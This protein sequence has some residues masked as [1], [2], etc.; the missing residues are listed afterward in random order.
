M[1]QKRINWTLIIVLLLGVAVLSISAYS[2]RKW[3]RSRRAESGLS[4]G[5]QAFDNQQWEAAARYLGRYLVVAPTDIPTL[6]KYAEAQLNIRPLKRNNIEQA[7]GAYRTILRVDETHAEAA[8]TLVGIYLQ[9]GLPGEAELI[10]GRAITKNP[11][12]NLQKMLAMAMIEQRKFD[13]GSKLLTSLIQNHPDYIPAYEEIARLAEKR[14]ERISRTSQEWYDQAVGSNPTH[15]A[16]YLLRGSW[17]LR[18]NDKPRAMADFTEAGKLDLSDTAIRL[19]LAELLIEAEDI[20]SAR[21]HLDAIEKSDP[22]NQMLW[23]V[24]AR[25]ALKSNQ[26]QAMKDAADR[27][28]ESLSAQPW[29]FLPVAA[30]LYIRSGHIK[31]AQDCVDRLSKKEISPAATEYLEGIIADKEGRYHDAAKYLYRAIQ[32]DSR[33]PAV[34]L[35]LAD[36]LSRLGDKQSA[37]QQLRMLVSEHP[38]FIGAK[39]SLARLLSESGNWDEASEL[40]RSVA[41]VQPKDTNAAMVYIQSEIQILAQNRTDKDSPL[42]QE[43]E[44]KLAQIEA[45]AENKFPIHLLQFQV[46]VLRSRFDVAGKLLESLGEKYPSRPELVMAQIELLTAQNQIDQAMAKLSGAVREFPES[47]S[48]TAYFATLL[49]EKDQRQ[50]SEQVLRDAL[51]RFKDPAARRQTGLL[52]A[53]FYDRWDQQDKRYETLDSLIRENPEDIILYSQI[54]KC[55]KTIDTPDLAQKMID[56]IKSL[57]GESGYRWRYEQAK[58]WFMD[59]DNGRFN[60]RYPQCVSMLKANLL[61]NPEDQSSR[62]LLAATYERAGELQLAIST[63]LEALDRAPRNMQIIVSTVAA[64]Y[65]ANEYDRVDKILR[66]ATR[67][68]LFHPELERLQLQSYLRRGQLSSAGAIL[69]NLLRNDPNNE[70]ICLSL[71]LLKI[72]QNEFDDAWVLLNKLKA[73]KPDSIPITA[74]EIECSVRQNK[75]QEALQICDNLIGRINT[76]SAYVLR[77]RTFSVLGQVDKA[78]ADLDYA[79]SKNPDDVEALV[80]RSDIYGAMGQS[81]KAIADIQKAMT[82]SDENLQIQM[83]AISLFLNSPDPLKVHQGRE[84]LNRV[85]PLYPDNMELRLYKARYLLAEGTAPSITEA[86]ALLTKITE[87]RPKMSQAWAMLAEISFMFKQTTKTADIILRGLV[88]QPNDPTLLMLKAQMEAKSSPLLAIPTLLSLLD[89]NPDDVEVIIRLSD[90][91]LSAGEA[92]KAV[93]LLKSKLA[94]P[95]SAADHRKLNII[96][97]VALY[98]NGDKTQAQNQFDALIKAIPDNP[99]PLLAQVRLCQEDGLWDV[100]IDKVTQWYQG[101]PDDTAVIL[102]ITRNLAMDGREGAGQAAETIL[103]TILRKEPSQTAAAGDL[104]ML[105]QMKGRWE[106][107]AQLYREILAVQP[108]N[109]VAI[110]NLAWILCENQQQYEQALTL[111]QQGIDKA[112]TDYVDLIDTRGTI[113][114]RMGQYEKAAQDFSQCLKLYPDGTP[115]LV[116]SHFH[117]AKTL[118]GLGRKDESVKFL[119]QTLQLNRDFGGLNEADLAEARRLLKELTGEA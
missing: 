77:A 1:Q 38:D 41:Q 23:Q 8:E 25:L 24:R 44:T 80:L 29:D 14:P 19:R 96:L 116:L 56:K 108:D 11:S 16:A 32:L 71:T 63:Y 6:L 69:E 107:A 54:L 104:A 93:S 3:Q 79:M 84:I 35:E 82:L 85:S 112:P 53:D 31:Q 81:D 89:R 110:N 102:V 57:E 66:Q 76:S 117:L 4:Q 15:A 20:D 75:P 52:L 5:N 70:S 30:E 22:A 106:Q 18:N 9:T 39:L 12:S 37:I 97:A 95:I 109:L 51:N 115:S 92:S 28:L 99:A 46:A 72:R 7:I 114:Y 43:I 111:A 62:M 61:S 42:W 50:Q 103:R 98:K 49:A 65:K 68:R 64:L 13:E 67:E 47:V 74:A 26:A 59:G 10:A 60:T 113:Y 17:Y 55:R 119:N 73:Q 101:N 86:Q 78:I 83:R 105:L 36:I 45:Q 88:H 100:V 58:L 94:S 27:G 48:V 33:N 40:A 91:Y 2:L 87:E 90:T 21:A 34:R 118:I